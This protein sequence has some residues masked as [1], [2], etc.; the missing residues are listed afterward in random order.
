[1]FQFN[2]PGTIKD[3]IVEDIDKEGEEVVSINFLRLTK[4]NMMIKIKNFKINLKMM[5]A[6]INK[7]KW[8]L[9]IKIKDSLKLV[10]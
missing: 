1:M 8:K 4:V 7:D 5:M 3:P 10:L 6:K 2:C 9:M